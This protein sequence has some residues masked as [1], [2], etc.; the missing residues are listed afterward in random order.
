M[1]QQ[2]RK[3]HRKPAQG[4]E[5]PHVLHDLL[6]LPDLLIH[7]EMVMQLETVIHPEA[8]LIH[9]EMV[10]QLHVRMLQQQQRQQQLQLG[11]ALLQPKP[12][13]QQ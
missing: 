4:E 8:L 5:R 13:A 7:Q 2:G 3:L 10:I 6:L 1:K 11:K 9:Q 12:A